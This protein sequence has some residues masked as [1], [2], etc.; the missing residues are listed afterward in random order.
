MKILRSLA[1]SLVLLLITGTPGY[2]CTVLFD[3]TVKINLKHELGNGERALPIA[4]L[5]RQTQSSQQEQ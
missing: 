1:G 3:R 2:A 5:F 4:S